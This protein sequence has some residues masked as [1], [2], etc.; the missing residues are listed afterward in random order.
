MATSNFSFSEKQCFMALYVEYVFAFNK[1]L[2]S[3]S[4][5]ICEKKTTDKRFPGVGGGVVGGMCY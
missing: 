5:G 3:K 4:N 2:Q 1:S